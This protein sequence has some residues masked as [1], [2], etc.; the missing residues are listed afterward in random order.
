[1]TDVIKSP[2]HCDLDLS[3]WKQYIGDITTNAR[4]LTALNDKPLFGHFVIPKREDL[5][6]IPS[7]VKSHHGL[8]ISEIPYQ[9]I[10]RFTKK[11]E[12][13]WS[14]FGGTGIDYDIATYLGRK[15][16][17]N[18][19]NPK[20]DF[21]QKADSRSFKTEKDI[22][23]ALLHPP[24]WD[25]VKYTESEEDGSSKSSLQEFLQWWTEII[26]NVDNQVIKEGYIVLACGNLYK[27]GEEIE[28]GE[29]LKNMILSKGYIL[30]QHII[31]DYGE[32]K[33]SEAKNYNLNYFRQLRGG[34]GN[35]YGDNIYILKKKKSKNNI[36]EMIREF[37]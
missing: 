37:I 9:M 23:L 21:I 27:N 26:E 2:K 30:K 13:V 36:V 6:K 17:I 22:K 15:C 19:L 10:M 29:I 4:W 8:W 14:V 16:I 31:K 5:P 28:L 1:V 34:Y 20:R 3:N 24:Y 32:T 18:D 12:Y 11:D 35:F 7:E 33:G 25:M